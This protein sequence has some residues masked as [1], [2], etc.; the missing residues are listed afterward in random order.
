MDRAHSGFLAVSHGAAGGTYGYG[1]DYYMQS[2]ERKG[3]SEVH[4][5]QNGNNGTSRTRPKDRQPLRPDGADH[6]A[7][8]STGYDRDDAFRDDDRISEDGASSA[9]HIIQ[10]TQA[11]EVSYEYDSQQQQPQGQMQHLSSPEHV[12]HEHPSPDMVH[13]V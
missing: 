6:S 2:L 12:S 10:K 8:I 9:K 3:L 4:T 5:S 13:A 7:V 1:N 11:W